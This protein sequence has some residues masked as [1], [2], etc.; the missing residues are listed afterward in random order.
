MADAPYQFAPW[1]RPVN[2]HFGARGGPPTYSG[3]ATFKAA[4]AS[5]TIPGDQG[6]KISNALFAVTLTGNAFVIP[7]GTTIARIQGGNTCSIQA[8]IY[9]ELTGGIGSSFNVF[10]QATDTISGA[11]IEGGPAG[12]SPG[13]PGFA[14]FS[15]GSFAVLPGGANVTFAFRATGDP[16]TLGFGRT[17]PGFVT[18]LVT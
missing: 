6:P 12:A 8:Y 3:T 14:H 17:D 7:E 10:L 16:V 1:E 13:A 18:L 15:L 2:V 5:F 4:G 9:A 11:T